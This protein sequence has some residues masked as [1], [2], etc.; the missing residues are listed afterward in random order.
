MLTK[1]DMSELKAYAKPPAAVELC[2]AGV[3]T[4]LKRPATWDEAKKQLGDTTFMDKLKEFD[5]DKLDDALLKKVE[6]FT[7]NPDYAPDAIGKVSGAARGLC[8]WTH[9]MYIYG[10]VSK[11]VAPKRA[12]LKAAQDNL[13][14]KQKSLNAAKEALAEVLAKVQLLKDKYD[15][16]TSNKAA[17][18]AELDDL[19]TKLMRAEKLV[20]GLAGERSR[21]EASISDFETKLAAL[22]GDV[23]VAAAF[24]SY[25]GPFP[26]EFREELVRATWL[27]QVRTLSIPAS[28]EFDFAAFLADPSDVRDWNIAGLPADSFS[29]ENGV[30]VTRGRRWPLMV[31]PQGQANKW[32]RNLEKARSLKLVTLSM[33][34]LIRQI[35]TALQ[36]GYPVLLQDIGEEIDP[37]LEPLL[38]KA[39]IKRGNQVLIKLGDK[40]ID[41]SPEFKLYLTTK[42]TNPHYTPEVS[43]KVTIINFTVKEQGLEAQLLN[44]VVQRERPDLDRQKNE[45]VVKVAHGKRT[46]A[47]L[48]DRIL[49][50]LSEATGSLLDNVGLINTLDESK[51]T[52]EEVNESLKV[53]EGTSRKI[54]AASAAYRPCSVRAALLYFVLND[55]GKVDTMYQFSLDAYA[56]LFLLSIAK[57]PKNEAVPE[58]IKALNEFHTYAVYK[59]A[60]RGLFEAHKLLL[61]LQIC[62]RVLAS[63]K[64]LNREE[65]SFFLSG[66][67]VVNR[68]AQPPN[69]APEWISEEAW[70][71]VTSAEEAL[72][73]FKG[74]VQSFSESRTAWE[75]WCA[76]ARCGSRW[77][78]FRPQ[79]SKWRRPLPHHAL[80]ATFSGFLLQVPEQRAGDRGAP[81]RVGGALQRAAAD[82]RRALPP[83]R[84]RHERRDRLRLQRPRCV[85]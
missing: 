55:L 4:V 36:F 6:K 45:L 77:A 13:E 19:E 69:V 82:D 25:A 72:P 37:V 8:L 67:Q 84:P 47:E 46:Q 83:R 34:D 2:L 22:P 78:H 18:E 43:T 74:I 38:A 44:T 80:S 62:A 10:N 32:V 54:E 14:K 23:V 79:S 21:W 85:R 73:A 29:T 50:M 70:D 75:K 7:S 63:S 59:Y 33:P 15:A 56:D 28:S 40:E 42:L 60:A 27:P 49:R 11:D 68:T 57:S 51:T 20:S 3:M 71:N 16:S 5:K 12:K 26:S 81:G 64:Q 76:R 65:W 39:F 9:A 58:R 66:G 24:S 61:S 35:E 31:D 1:K 41:Y 52:W 48:E 30:L 53:A 17:L